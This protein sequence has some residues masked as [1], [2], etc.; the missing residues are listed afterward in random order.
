MDQAR[1]QLEAS[2]RSP[3]LCNEDYVRRLVDEAFQNVTLD[4]TL[5]ASMPRGQKKVATMSGDSRCGE[6][7]AFLKLLRGAGGEPVVAAGMERGGLG[8]KRQWKV[9]RQPAAA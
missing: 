6:V 2:L 3:E 1:A 5:S 7:L 9:R 4:T 8:E